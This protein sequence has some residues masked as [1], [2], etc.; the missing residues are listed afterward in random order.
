MTEQRRRKLIQI[1]FAALLARKQNVQKQYIYEDRNVNNDAAGQSFSFEPVLRNN[2]ANMSDEEYMRKRYYSEVVYQSTMDGSIET[3]IRESDPNKRAARRLW[4][5]RK[6]TGWNGTGKG[7]YMES[8]NPGVPEA[9]GSGLGTASSE[10]DQLMQIYLEKQTDKMHILKSKSQQATQDLFR[11]IAEHANKTTGKTDLSSREYSPSYKEK[12]VSFSQFQQYIRPYVGNIPPPKNATRAEQKEWVSEAVA[13]FEASPRAGLAKSRTSLSSPMGDVEG[14]YAEQL[15]LSHPQFFDTFQRQ[16]L[17]ANSR[18]KEIIEW[19]NPD[20]LYDDYEIVD[21]FFNPSH[22]EHPGG[23]Q[24]G[25][26]SGRDGG[27]GPASG[28]FPGE[29]GYT[30]GSTNEEISPVGLT[31]TIFKR[32]SITDVYPLSWIEYKKEKRMSANIE[33]YNAG[34][35]LNMDPVLP[36]TTQVNSVGEAKEFVRWMQKALNDEQRKLNELQDKMYLPRADSPTAVGGIDNQYLYK[37]TF[38][39]QGGY[40]DTQKLLAWGPGKTSMSAPTN[41]KQEIAQGMMRDY[42]VLND[43]VKYKK[44]NDWLPIGPKKKQQWLWKNQHRV[45]RGVDMYFPQQGGLLRIHMSVR[46]VPEVAYNAQGTPPARS[47]LVIE[48]PKKDGIKFL[49]DVKLTLSEFE[50]Q[51]TKHAE[52]LKAFTSATKEVWRKGAMSQYMGA[53]M[54]TQGGRASRLFMGDRSPVNSTAFFTNT[55]TP[56]SFAANLKSLVDIGAKEWWSNNKGFNSFFDL[57]EM[58]G[59]A[60]KEWALKWEEESRSLESTINKNIEAKWKSWVSQFAGGGAT[61]PPPRIAKTWSSPIKLGPFVHSTNKMGEAQSVGR[62]K[63]GYYVQGDMYGGN[64]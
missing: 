27:R 18:S 3:S 2:E 7:G 44:F 21:G 46:V 16:R 25:P 45:N 51:T 28:N 41:Y 61:A 42:G 22:E 8:L 52:S 43:E 55:Q 12:G 32:E 4:A 47:F 50:I 60:F 48:I 14:Q 53:T 13:K 59:G 35:G 10:S 17:L 38:G 63:H 29:A 23:Q 24:L 5:G 15:A 62:R 56:Q 34:R 20:G 19:Y 6:G 36:A 1:G 30:Q 31:K 40:S 9:K 11:K 37:G 57:H 39:Q 26:R 64:A 58:E 33:E 54:I 49:P